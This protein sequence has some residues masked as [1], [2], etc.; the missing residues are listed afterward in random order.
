[1]PLHRV[2]QLPGEVVG[3]LDTRVQA[4]ATARRMPVRG[5]TAAEHPATG[6]VG[7]VLLVDEPHRPVEDLHLQVG[8]ADQ[9]ADP[10]DQFLVGRLGHAVLDQEA[11]AGDPLG[12]WR[13]AAQQAQADLAD[14]H[15]GVE[16]PVQDARPVCDVSAEVAA[17]LGV[18]RP[19]TV[20]VT[21]ERQADAVG[22]DRPGA[23]GPDQVAGPDDLVRP[24]EP[25]PEPGGHPVGVL[26]EIEQFGP[27][28]DPDA[29]A[30]GRVDEDRLD[31]VLGNVEVLA[32]AV[33]DVVAVPGETGAPGGHPGD[34]RSGQADRQQGVAHLGPWGGDGAGPL[35]QAEVAEHLHRPLA[36]DVGPRGVRHPGGLGDEA[37]G[38]ALLGEGDRGRQ[39]ERPGADDQDVGGA[40]CCRD[41]HLSAPPAAAGRPRGGPR[42]REAGPPRRPR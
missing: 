26:F 18:E 28:A 31:P 39:A 30:P 20:L 34:L 6:V 32:R 21:L 9:L 8:H 27:V 14:V 10:A 13:G 36:G 15:L 12:P 37:Y 33:A 17:E 38:D 5:V 19:G 22:D 16:E 35:L 1:M 42:G 4:Q 2:R 7:G 11:P 24:A 23:V 41:R 25:V 3:V 29:V 40:G